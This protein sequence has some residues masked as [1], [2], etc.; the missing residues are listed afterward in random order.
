MRSRI[1]VDLIQHVKNTLGID[2]Q[3]GMQFL[4]EIQDF[5]RFY[6][7]ARGEVRNH[8]GRGARL[9]IITC[10]ARI[11]DYSDDVGDIEL[12][13]RQFEEAIQTFATNDAVDEARVLRV[14][15][16]PGLF[17]NHRIGDLQFQILY[18]INYD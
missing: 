6:I 5:P 10:D 11:Y 4:H 17:G 18:R 8:L 16:D 15:T 13:V 3:R 12:R 7:H 14:R 2:G 1:L 9:G